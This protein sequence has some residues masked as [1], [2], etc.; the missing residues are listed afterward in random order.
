MDFADNRR[1]DVINYTRQ[2]YGKDNVAQIGTFG[3]MMARGACRDVAR[4]M[5]YPLP[6]ADKIA[7]LVPMARKAFQ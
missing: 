5:G 4:A 7:K 6:L 2:K 1:D 3:T